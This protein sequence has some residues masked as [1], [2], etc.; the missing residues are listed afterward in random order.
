MIIDVNKLKQQ[1]KTE[2]SFSFEYVPEGQLIDLP[3]AV[4]D[5]CVKVNV[6]ATLSGRDLYVDGE[7]TFTVNGECSRCLEKATVPVTVSFSA[8]FSLLAG[9]EYP[10]KA[11]K[12]DL[13]PIVNEA[14]IMD[15][16]MVIYCKDDCKGICPDCGVN[17]NKGNCTCKN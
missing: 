6:T 11:G 1:G 9:A 5:G 10:I 8:E 4:I 17:L 16:P 12:A 3:N 7:A 2:D 13:T 14:I 15:M